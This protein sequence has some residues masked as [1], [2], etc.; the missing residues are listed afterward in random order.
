MDLARVERKMLKI[1]S[2]I[3]AGVLAGPLV[4]GASS[5]MPIADSPAIIPAKVS[6]IDTFELM[7]I[8]RDLP[9]QAYDAF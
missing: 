4:W 9:A 2:T 7:S 6:Q 8:K 3:L 1:K 5:M